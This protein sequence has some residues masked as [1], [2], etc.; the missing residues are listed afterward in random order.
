MAPLP[1]IAPVTNKRGR[2]RG[3]SMA[4][5]RTALAVAIVLSASEFSFYRL[6]LLAVQFHHLCAAVLKGQRYLETAVE[7][8]SRPT[9]AENHTQYGF[10]I[11]YTSSF[12]Q[13]LPCRHWAEKVRSKR[14]ECR[15]LTSHWSAALNP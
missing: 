6:L 8:G 3:R 1:H 13:T 15:R 2:C 9:I 5:L 4:L 10:V 14:I 7:M 11:G 12:S